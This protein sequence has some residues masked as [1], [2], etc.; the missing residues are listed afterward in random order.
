LT[1]PWLMPVNKLRE[2]QDEDCSK[3]SL[4]PF[5]VFRSGTT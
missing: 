2:K 5:P 4:W 3:Q 1:P